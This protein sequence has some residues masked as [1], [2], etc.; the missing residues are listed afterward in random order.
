MTGEYIRQD[1]VESQ[2]GV[3]L[4]LEFQFID[5]STCTAA[6]GLYL[7]LWNANS[8]GVYSGVVVSGNG[9]GTTDASNIN[10]TF[11]RGIQETDSEGIASFDTLFPGHYAGRASHTHVMAHQEVELFSNSTMTIGTVSHVGQ[12]FWQ[13][14]LKDE[15]ELTYPYVSQTEKTKV[16]CR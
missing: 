8:T 12:L 16:D 5:I 1:L 9:D 7:D 14:T 2:E 15:V 11:L 4:H 6:S 10:A 3:A 13:T